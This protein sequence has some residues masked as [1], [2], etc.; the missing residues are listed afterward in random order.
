MASPTMFQRPRG[1]ERFLRQHEALP[2]YYRELAPA[3]DLLDVVACRWVSVV[4]HG[5]FGVRTPI[6]PDGCSDIMLY[7]ADAP[8]VVGPD[9][10]MRWTDLSDGLVITGLRLRPGAM[11]AVFGCSASQLLDRQMLLR[12]VGR[13]SMRFLDALNF[14]ETLQGRHALLEDWVRDA[15][16]Q[17][18]ATDRV[19][20]A[21]C[22]AL[23]A[24]PQLAIGTLARQLGWNARMIHR[25]FKA[26]CG[27]GPKHLQRVMRVQAALRLAHGASRRLRLPDI[28]SS[29]GFADQAHMSREFRDLTGFT[30]REYFAACTPEVGAWLAGEINAAPLS[31]SFKTNG[32][33]PS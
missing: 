3:T 13:V 20:L 30:P 8:H 11:R 24:D 18:S 27:Y 29:A 28:A 14:A 7:D 16:W 2:G 10:R 21:A 25:Q 32:G 22:R 33:G 12:D 4:R 9:S 1:V 26:A 15:S 19:L 6:I 23:A 17:R 5:K 31:E